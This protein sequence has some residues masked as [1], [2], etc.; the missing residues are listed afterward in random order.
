M[1]LHSSYTLNPFVFA[2]N[3]IFRWGNTT[4]SQTPPQLSGIPL[5]TPHPSRP[6]CYPLD[7]EGVDGNAA[8]I[9][10]LKASV[11]VAFLPAPRVLKDTKIL[12]FK[13]HGRN[14]IPPS[15]LDLNVG[16]GGHCPFCWKFG[17]GTSSCCTPSRGGL[18]EADVCY[19]W[20]C[21]GSVFW[22]AV[23]NMTL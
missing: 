20:R 5:H 15:N 6:L 23:L 22:H 17:G 1:F 14:G 12:R 4:L 10:S 9:W 18:L 8:L 7:W 2:E 21:G 19:R 11:P 16:G 3:K 13:F